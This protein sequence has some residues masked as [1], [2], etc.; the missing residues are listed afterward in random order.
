[1][2][3][4]IAMQLQATLGIVVA[5]K[6]GAPFNPE[7]ALG[8]V[9]EE[10]TSF[11]NEEVLDHLRLGRDVFERAA[12]RELEEVERMVTIFRGHPIPDLKGS[13]AVIVDDGLAT[14]ATAAAAA[15]FLKLKNAEVVI[16]APV[17]SPATVKMLES[18]A[19]EVVCP[20]QPRSLAAVGSWYRDFS[21]TT[22][23]EVIRLLDR[24]AAAK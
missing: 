21:Q 24:G 5:R 4:E 7:L 22:E 3:Y 17:G 19:V 18:Q 13:T 6:V 10:G 11:V 20:D 8:A 9:S 16:A 12:R 14:G 1:M 23:E 2:A 15:C